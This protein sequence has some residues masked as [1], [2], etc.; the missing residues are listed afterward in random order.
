MIARDRVLWQYLGQ[1]IRD[2][3]A[4]QGRRATLAKAG[5]LAV[6]YRHVLG[7][8][9]AARARRVVRTLTRRS[10][11]VILLLCP[12]WDVMMPP[13][14]LG[15]LATA[16]SRAGFL[17]AVCDLN[18]DLYRSGTSEEQDWWLPA[19]YGAWADPVR[20]APMIDRF[21][22]RV[23]RYLDQVLALPTRVIGL[24][25]HTSNKLF[26]CDVARRIRERDP[27]RLI[28]MG[29]NGCFTECMRREIPAELVDAFVVG[30]G[31]ITLVE[32]LRALRR[33]R[34][35]LGIP[36]VVVRQGA[37]FSA[38]QPRPVVE[39]LDTLPFPTFAEFDPSRYV[40]RVLPLFASRGCI[41]SCAFCNDWVMGRHFR[42]R[43][44]AHIVQEIRFH[45][46]HHGTSTFS[47]KD[48]LCN[49]DLVTLNQFC[50]LIVG[51][52]LKIHWDSQAIPRRQMTPELLGKMRASGCEQLTYGMES[53]SSPVLRDMRKFQTKEIL[54]RVFQDTHEAGIQVTVNLIVGFPGETEAEFEETLAFL[55]EVHPHVDSIGAISTL[56]VNNDSEL[57]RFPE[58]FGIVLSDDPSRRSWDWVSKDGQ[59]TFA[60]RQARAR[61]LLAV[62]DGLG[63]EY[64]CNNTE[65]GET[66]LLT[67]ETIASGSGEPARAQEVA[68]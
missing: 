57:D 60:L 7:D 19:H 35:L 2:E 31:E 39:Q 12:T 14:S 10:P 48:L 44:A 51:S 63:L 52:G 18:I 38:L 59:N 36:G 16:V 20:C 67:R 15:Y 27:R 37:G 65:D 42:S 25:V 56:Y 28:V 55:R 47:F 24:S 50:D 53:G 6:A 33:G 58:R 68:T 30:E 34:P 40:M 41:A 5:Q 54:R 49:G 22:A 11:D 29:G 1:V 3:V 62:L 4:R 23:D 46:A 66:L 8:L 45:I 26:T 61:C 21:A 9:V 17:P 13:L 64:A 32:L 43:S